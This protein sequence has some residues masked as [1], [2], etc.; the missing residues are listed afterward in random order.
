MEAII[1]VYNNSWRESCCYIEV[2][3]S[4]N[5]LKKLTILTSIAATTL[6]ECDPVYV[7]ELRNNTDHEIQVKVFG[8]D[9]YFLNS[10]YSGEE[11]IM[12]DSIADCR[13]IEVKNAKKIFLATGSKIAKPLT[14]QDLGFDEIEVATANGKV[15]ATGKDIMDLFKI[16]KRR[17]IMGIHT[18]DL[19]YI[20]IAAEKKI[21]NA[22]QQQNKASAPSGY[23]KG[24]PSI[25]FHSL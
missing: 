25:T 11:L 4:G 13:I 12:A 10:D 1:G 21:I 18:S 16:E 6:I 23:C 20:D 7:G 24:V 22:A 19:Y 2:G 5:M 8:L 17:N 15:R 14:Y 3:A 9:L